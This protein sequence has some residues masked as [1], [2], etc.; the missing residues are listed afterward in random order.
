MPSAS[1]FLARPKRLGERL[2]A[3][4]RRRSARLLTGAAQEL[5]GPDESRLRDTSLDALLTSGRPLPAALVTHARVRLAAEQPEG[6][7]ALGYSLYERAETRELGLLVLGVCH[8][9]LSSPKAAWKDFSRIED[10]KLVVAAAEKW[11]DAAF[12][13]EPEAGRA[14]LQRL[15]DEE[16]LPSLKS[17][18]L[19]RVAR[20]AFARG[21]EDLARQVTD[22]CLARP[23]L[24]DDSASRRWLELL[25]TWYSDGAR[26][27]PQRELPADLRFG[28]LNYKQPDNS[29]RN[30]GD[31]VQTIASLG[32][33]VRHQNLS[34]VGEDADLVG[35][36][37]EL[38]GSVKP[39]RVISDSPARSIQ[40]VEVQ[41]DAST[42][43]ELPDRT[44]ML[45]FGWFMHDTYQLG[46]NF[47]FNASIRPIFIS[48]HLNRT[49]M[50]TPEVVE[51]LRR[52]APIGCRDWHSVIA[53]RDVGVPAFFSGCITTTIDTVFPPGDPRHKTHVGYVDYTGMPAEAGEH[54]REQSIRDVRYRP[55][56]ENLRLA[57]SW[58]ADYNEK[59]RKLYTSRLHC[60]LPATS[61]GCDVV[62]EP[63]NRSDIRFGGLIDLDPAGFE[64]IRQRI[65]QMVSAV[66]TKVFEGAGEDEVYAYWGELCAPE[67]AAAEQFL[68][69][70][71]F[72]LGPAPATIPVFHSG[73]RHVALV[74]V[75]P[76]EGR[77]V[78]VALS[79]LAEHGPDDLGVVI[80]GAEA[81]KLD[82]AALSAKS[83]LPVELLHPGTLG[84]SDLRWADP[85]TRP[86]T[87]EL[88]LAAALTS[89]RES[90][91]ALLL[92]VSTVIREDLAELFELDL[93]DHAVAAIPDPQRGRQ[94]G[95]E[96]IRYLGARQGG[97]WRKGLAFLAAATRGKGVGFT[98]F[99]ATVLLL[100]PQ[101][102]H[103][104]GYADR[105]CGIVSG[106]LISFRDML[107][108][109]IG[110]DRAT[111]A[112]R[113]NT[114][115]YFETPEPDPAVVAYRVLKPWGKAFVPFR[116]E[117]RRARRALAG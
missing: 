73:R 30:V 50:L 60:Y 76:G 102:L 114:L 2:L 49:D 86:S 116:S 85:A 69:E 63:A 25:T 46:Y 110:P 82:A 33:V 62:F 22:H 67:V 16:L 23:A 111:L 47:P 78:P 37:E 105:A 103:A 55:L 56:A 39:E 115:P 10:S 27:V 81:K 11:F 108:V 64:A 14:M 7:L 38:A 13:C 71:Q 1:S 15:V 40:L 5:Q 91:R 29:S 12:K 57:R 74:S 97:D 61:V 31:W 87:R 100:D 21:H 28:V 54:V 94:S 95:A 52:Y 104:A 93:G 66:L 83:G 9:T 41:R 19:F 89:V 32:H 92:P 48:F 70:Q 98:L 36:V 75:E 8:H 106:H 42:L 88:V 68:A 20:Q 45:A 26:R 34:F 72:R 58:I 3:A 99:D 77:H 17:A 113:Y 107:N 84:L 59:Y 4:A 96:L 112:V 101:R 44:W 18:E 6:P 117:W 43:Q 80:V 51:Y 109:L 65:L 35:F 90:G 79:M 53:L 24:P